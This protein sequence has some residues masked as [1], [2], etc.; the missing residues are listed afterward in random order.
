VLLQWP[1]QNPDDTFLKRANTPGPIYVRPPSALQRLKHVSIG[2]SQAAARQRAR[3]LPSRHCK[4]TATAYI[5]PSQFGC[6][7][8]SK[9]PCICLCFFSPSAHR[10][11]APASL[12]SR[13]RSLLAN[14]N[15]SGQHAAAGKESGKW[16]QFAQRWG[17]VRRVHQ[18]DKLGSADSLAVPAAGT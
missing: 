9:V 12:D 1:D 14:V 15:A 4:R 6:L 7:Q 2:V 5:R 10:R 16:L 18:H 17:V 13:S 8:P 3:L 11:P